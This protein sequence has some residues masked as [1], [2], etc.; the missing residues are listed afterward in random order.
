MASPFTTAPPSLPVFPDL[1]STTR[2][3]S[4]MG[5]EPDDFEASDNGLSH[6]SE[7]DITEASEGGEVF[8]LRQQI[9]QLWE[10]LEAYKSKEREAKKKQEETPQEPN[11]DVKNATQE[12]EA[13]L[14][15]LRK[16]L[17][18]QTERELNKVSFHF[19]ERGYHKPLWLSR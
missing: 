5:G 4:H 16:M 9:L 18:D 3:H 2:R 7:Q 10:E 12:Y 14:D 19:L 13:E 11:L 17:Q 8:L 15:K 1:P 6:G